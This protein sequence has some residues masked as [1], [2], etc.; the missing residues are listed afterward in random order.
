MCHR[1]SLNY[2][3]SGGVKTTYHTG[4]NVY[5][6]AWKF[7]CS[8]NLQHFLDVIKQFVELSCSELTLKFS[9]TKNKNQI[10]TSFS[11]A[12]KHARTVM[13]AIDL[14]VIV[15][16][17]SGLQLLS[18]SRCCLSKEDNVNLLHYFYLAPLSWLFS[19]PSFQV[20]LQSRDKV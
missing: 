1:C 16:R 15:V 8:K 17:L 2:D 6:L 11:L 14:K 20:Q 5:Q 12:E 7:S 10:A 3:Q 18:S 9:Y 19:L 13:R 4:K